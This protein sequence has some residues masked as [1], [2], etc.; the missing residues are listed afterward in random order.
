MQ[1]MYGVDGGRRL[2]EVELPWLAGYEGSRPVRIGNGAYE[3]VQVD[4]F[5]ELVD[6]FH[7]ARKSHL[8]PNDDAWRFQCSMLG[9]LERLWR[10]P[11]SEERRVGKECVL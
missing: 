11:R 10:D 7:A 6:A 5:G 2:T 4:V 1:I 9:R 8:G 3:Q